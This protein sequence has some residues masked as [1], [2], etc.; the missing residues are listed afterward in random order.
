MDSDDC[1]LGRITLEE[2]REIIANETEFEAIYNAI[3]E[4]QPYPDFAGGS[5]VSLEIY[6]LEGNARITI[7]FKR[8]S[9][10]DGEHT[11]VLFPK[12]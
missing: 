3:S 11:G 7:F 6:S 10:V 9:Y 5:G 1:L 8:I 4:K 2:V 12:E